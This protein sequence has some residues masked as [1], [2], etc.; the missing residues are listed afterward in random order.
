M[1]GCN[2]LYDAEPPDINPQLRVHRDIVGHRTFRDLLMVSRHQP[3]APSRKCELI[4]KLLRT[5]RPDQVLT[6][7]YF[8]TGYA[9]EKFILVSC[10]AINHQL[11][12]TTLESTGACRL[13][14]RMPSGWPGGGN[15][16][17]CSRSYHLSYRHSW[18]AG[19]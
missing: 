6:V 2:Q 10:R 12:G 9:E 8:R 19:F 7:D 17:G 1:A 3:P 16:L 11:G 14:T 4:W 13:H 15:G 18:D 5:H